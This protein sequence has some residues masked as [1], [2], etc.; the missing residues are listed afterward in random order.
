MAGK[1]SGKGGKGYNKNH[2]TQCKCCNYRWNYV[3]RGKCFNCSETLPVTIPRLADDRTPKWPSDDRKVQREENDAHAPSTE[4]GGGQH[5]VF[6]KQQ[7]TSWKKAGYSDEDEV[8]VSLSKKIEANKQKSFEEKD[9]W[10]RS[11]IR[12]QRIVAMEKDIE[13][14]KWA[15]AD[16]QDNLQHIQDQIDERKKSVATSE[17]QVAL[18]KAEARADQAEE[19]PEEKQSKIDLDGFFKGLDL[20]AAE[21]EETSRLI[22]EAKSAFEKLATLKDKMVVAKIEKDKQEEHRLEGDRKRKAKPGEGDPETTQMDDDEDMGIDPTVFENNFKE[23]LG[24]HTF[25]PEVLKKLTDAAYSTAKKAR[26][27]RM[28]PYCASESARAADG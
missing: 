7:L 25:E 17:T 15:V 26:V 16:L 6:L 1:S 13:K 4:G 18:L 10:T 12:A 2:F 24:E 19:T 23:Q 21:N 3:W 27:A 5:M 9:T 28:G 11:Q 8:L 20:D 22:E 14:G